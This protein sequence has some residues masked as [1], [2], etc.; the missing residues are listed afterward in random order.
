L[1]VTDGI[2]NKSANPLRLFARSLVVLAWLETANARQALDGTVVGISDGDTITVLDSSQRQHRIRLHQIDAPE[3]RQ[4]FGQRSKQSLSDLI[5]SKPVRVE[6]TTIDKYGR[7][8][9]K[10]WIHGTDANLEQIKRGWRWST[11]NT[12]A[13]R[14]ISLRRKGRA[15][16]G[17]G[18]GPSPILSRLGNSGM[19]ANATRKARHR[20]HQSSMLTQVLAVA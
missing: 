3:K 2:K 12:R 11:G 17:L 18:Y 15:A 20:R 9:G 16:P 5:F 13:I 14:F 6:V 19:A 4:D 1:D 7:E 8:V 10:V